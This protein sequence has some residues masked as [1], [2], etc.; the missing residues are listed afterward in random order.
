MSRLNYGYPLDIPWLGTRHDGHPYSSNLSTYIKIRR[1]ATSSLLDD[2]ALWLGAM[3]FGLLEAVTGMKIPENLFL[4]SGPVERTRVLSGPRLLR[5]LAVWQQ[6]MR[7]HAWDSSEARELRGRAVPLLRRA[8]NA[9]VEEVGNQHVGI[10]S[11]AGH[12]VTEIAGPVSMLVVVLC[13]HLASMF[14]GLF[15]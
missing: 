14:R 11:R 9:L 1:S 10:L 8:F 3:T 12:A 7:S 13:G 15:P 6:S 5:F 2:A 4:A